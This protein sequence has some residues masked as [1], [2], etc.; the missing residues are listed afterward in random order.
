LALDVVSVSVSLSWP[1]G[2][3]FV[4]SFLKL[5]FFAQLSFRL[6][7]D[8]PDFCRFIGDIPSH[9]LEQLAE[10]DHRKSL[11]ASTMTWELPTWVSNSTTV[12]GISGIGQALSHTLFSCIRTDKIDALVPEA[13]LSVRFEYDYQKLSDSHATR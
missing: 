9:T 13:F 12:F 3:K 11:I 8:D 7:H 1:H 4:D 2:T 6:S 5:I 10:L